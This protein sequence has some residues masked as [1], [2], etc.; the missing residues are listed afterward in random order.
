[1]INN[2]WF[3]M[4]SFGIIVA[5]I[6]GRIDEINN[7]IISSAN[8]AVKLCLD[9]LGVLCFW[10]GL[11]KIIE[12]S[13][14]LSK[15]SSF[16]KPCLSYLF[17]DVPKDHPAIY[18]MIMNLVANFFGLGNAATPL[19]IKAIKELQKLNKKKDTCSNSMGLFLILNT[20]A[21]QLI[22]T[23]II[24]LRSSAGSINPSQVLVPIWVAS[25]C[26]NF[27]G[28]F[29]FKMISIKHKEDY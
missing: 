16:L 7:I 8:N 2:I 23:T 13:G 14:V 17:P 4:L 24:A 22:P 9:L 3:V 19:G 10:T 15:I 18:A 6:T 20:C 1:M 27:A 21:F 11:M 12:K 29:V 25:I 28:I 5:A 26:A